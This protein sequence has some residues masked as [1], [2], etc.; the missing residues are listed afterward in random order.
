[1][2]CPEP[3]A[4]STARSYRSSAAEACWG[5]PDALRKR[6]IL[7]SRSFGYVGRYLAYNCAWRSSSKR[8]IDVIILDFNPL[9]RLYLIFRVFT[10]CASSLSRVSQGSVTKQATI[11]MHA[12]K[13]MYL[14][15]CTVSFNMH[16]R[17]STINFIMMEVLHTCQPS[18]FSREYTGI[19][20]ALLPYFSIPDFLAL[21]CL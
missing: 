2:L 15:E 16:D 13:A 19:S 4:T 6:Q 14:C 10:A 21:F 18:R 8:R 3:H 12:Y 7:F 1:M 17:R 9:V 5:L 20:A 11:T